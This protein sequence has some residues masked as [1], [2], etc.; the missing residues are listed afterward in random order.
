METWRETWADAW[1]SPVM[2]R[3]SLD[4]SPLHPS[5][6]RATRLPNREPM[7]CQVGNMLADT[8]DAPAA[9]ARSCRT[10]RHGAV[11]GPG[12]TQTDRSHGS[13]EHRS[14]WMTQRS[15]P[16]SSATFRKRTAPSPRRP[17]SPAPTSPNTSLT[18]ASA[19]QSV[20]KPPRSAS[21]KG[22]CVLKN[23]LVD[24]F[25]TCQGHHTSHLTA[26]SWS[27]L[28]TKTGTVDC[29]APSPPFFNTQG[30]F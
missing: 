20:L 8:T 5:G 25:D 26:E 18:W 14:A 4:V 22:T 21:Q 9:A 13:P 28:G 29:A 12:S 3:R 7:R 17:T 27:N 6:H 2:K 15:A 16:S 30:R 24:T 19:A 10:D 23:S 11:A 1:D